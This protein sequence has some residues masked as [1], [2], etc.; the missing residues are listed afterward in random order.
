MCKGSGRV[1]MKGAGL[2]YEIRAW[3]GA[4]YQLSRS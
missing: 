4:E 3:Q 2:R 1:Y